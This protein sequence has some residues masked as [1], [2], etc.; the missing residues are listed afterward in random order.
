MN[1]ITKTILHEFLQMHEMSAIALFCE[2]VR[3]EKQGTYSLMGIVGD[4]LRVPSLPGAIPK[5]V[6]YVRINIPISC[7]AEE[8]RLYLHYPNGDRI[9]INTIREDL[10]EKTLN[11][12]RSMG[13]PIAGIFSH[14]VAAPFPVEQ[15]GRIAVELESTSGSQVIGSI[16]FDITQDSSESTT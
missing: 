12:A 3:E 11:D 1:G 15:A 6:I 10:V 9:L 7:T 14:L 13:N 4:N 8:L 16:H 5:F 2:D